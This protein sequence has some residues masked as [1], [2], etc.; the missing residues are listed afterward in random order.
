MGFKILSIYPTV[1]ATRIAL[2]DEEKEIKRVELRHD[3][4]DLLDAVTSEKQYDI[5]RTAVEKLFGG[6]ISGAD[7]IEAVIGCAL[8]PSGMSSGVYLLDGE[9]SKKMRITRVEGRVINYGALLASFIAREM[10]ARAFAMVPFES[11]EMDVIARISGV[12]GL[13]FGRLTHTLQIKNALRLAA[14]DL[15]KP[16]NEL[17][18][19]MA[20]LGHNFSFC[21]H[22]N[23]RIKDHSNTFERGP[24]SPARSGSLPAAEVIR[25]AYSGMWSKIDLMERAYYSGGLLSYTGAPDGDIDA[26]ISRMEEGDVYS[27]LLIRAMAYQIAS[28]IAAQA[29]VLKGRVDAIVFSGSCMENRIFAE[30]LREK[31]SW[32]SSKILTYRGEDELAMISDG[33]LRVLRNEETPRSCG[34]FSS[35]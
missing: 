13:C 20:Y 27:S 7:N 32:I 30:M 9:F 21:S 3:P 31:I 14:C 17:S 29:V 4:C 23:G 34:A 19:V 2:F 28:E 10:G 16:Q 11:D 26:V 35:K 22:R 33:A 15:K 5:R 12:P 18:F 1:A 24:F 25:M 8:L 6:W